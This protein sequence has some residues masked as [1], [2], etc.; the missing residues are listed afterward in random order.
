MLTNK[1]NFQHKGRTVYYFVKDIECKE[2]HGKEM[3]SAIMV[4]CDED[5]AHIDCF[6]IYDERYKVLYAMPSDA[7]RWYEEY[8]SRNNR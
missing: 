8:L 5:D 3:A 1:K 7:L 2:K 6:S 4:I